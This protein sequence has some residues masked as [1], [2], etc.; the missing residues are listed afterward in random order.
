M[1][2]QDIS[3]LQP[4]RGFSKMLPCGLVF[5]SSLVGRNHCMVVEAPGLWCDISL[6]QGRAF[7]VSGNCALQ[8]SLPESIEG[9]EFS[10]ETDPALVIK[11]GLPGKIALTPAHLP[12]HLL[13][14]FFL[15]RPPLS[16]SLPFPL[17]SDL[18]TLLSWT[19]WKMN[20]RT[21]MD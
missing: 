7:Y 9:G 20:K 10:L 21:A 16:P 17:C 8:P 5:S 4:G 1:E 13:F 14:L 19:Q 12:S 3:W 2:I 6:S 11:T 15:S 18:S